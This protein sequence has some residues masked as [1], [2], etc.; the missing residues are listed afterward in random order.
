MNCTHA[1]ISKKGNT[2]NAC[3]LF[4]IWYNHPISALFMTSGA[5]NPHQPTMWKRTLS[6]G[7]VLPRCEKQNELTC[8]VLNSNW[9]NVTSVGIKEEPGKGL[10]IPIATDPNVLQ[11]SIYN[12]LDSIK[13]ICLPQLPSITDCHFRHRSISAFVDS[14]KLIDLFL[15]LS[16]Y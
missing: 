10:P 1:S 4:K 16:A 6:S 2:V 14:D 11:T 5:W 13:I 3:N 9:G 7:E 12:F 15:K 8:Q